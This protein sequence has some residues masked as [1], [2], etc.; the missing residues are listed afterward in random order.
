MARAIKRRKERVDQ[1]LLRLQSSLADAQS[2]YDVDVGRRRAAYESELA[3]YEQVVAQ[4]RAEYDTQLQAYN[5][6]VAEYQSAQQA[7]AA[8]RQSLLSAYQR[9]VDAYNTRRSDYEAEVLRVNTDYQN[10]LQAQQAAYANQ[11]AAYNQAYGQYQRQADEFDQRRL[12]YIRNVQGA[13]LEFGLTTA[14][15][16]GRGQQSAYGTSSQ[17]S[18]ASETLPSGA[19]LESS[20]VGGGRAYIR[21]NDP[22]IQFVPTRRDPFSGDQLGYL[23]VRLPSGGF[24]S[25]DAGPF[26]PS[27][28]PTFSATAPT[29]PAPISAPTLPTA[30]TAPAAPTLPPFTMQAPNA[31]A[32]P[33]APPA[34]ALPDFSAEDAALQDEIARETEYY[35][36]EIAE[37]RAGRR[38]ARQSGGRRPIVAPEQI[39]AAQQPNLSEGQSLGQV[40]FLGGN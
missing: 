14:S 11:M 32:R 2:R 25:L 26:N 30:P 3:S 36:R 21:P 35:D 24:T 17:F 12:G 39:A 27:S 34:P 29:Q 28:R 9:E 23:R 1:N 10:Q 37:R 7:N 31:P 13:P 22:N 15:F 5:A 20:V 19:Y 16:G 38:R 18:I 6:R 40:G 8:Q 33:E 4:Q